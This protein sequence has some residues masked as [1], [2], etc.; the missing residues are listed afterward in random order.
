MDKGFYNERY[1]TQGSTG[2]GAYNLENLFRIRALT[3]WLNRQT[4]ISLLDV[5]CGVGGLC[6][7]MYERLGGA[8]RIKEVA[9]VDLI[10][11]IGENLI[12]KIHFETCNLN[13]ENLPFA[14]NAYNLIFCN[15]VAEHLFNTE[16]LFEELYRVVRTDGL[17]VVSVPNLAWWANRIFLLLGIQPI[18][19]E[20][21][22]KSI[23]YG[24]G[25]FSKRQKRFLPA[26]H[27]RCFT[28]AALRDMGESSGF[29]TI[30]WWSQDFIPGAQFFPR[31]GRSIG[32]VLKK[33]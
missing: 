15:H 24:A 22:T 14:D 1:Q 13:E 18:G 17:V 26:G 9:G 23:T 25:L 21:G 6:C 2:R 7:Q 29:A 5:G 30:G 27:I 31:L 16:H 4:D 10:N 12:A 3:R 11:A 32:I 8:G 19:T 28:P 33:V 20:V